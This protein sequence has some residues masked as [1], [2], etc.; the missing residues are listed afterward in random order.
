MD[1]EIVKPAKTPDRYMIAVRYRD[2]WFRIIA[3]ALAAQFIVMYGIEESFFEVLL[4]DLYYIAMAGSIII[5][6]V[7]IT[8][9]RWVTIKLDRRFGWTERTV[10]RV[11]LQVLLGWVA[12]GLFAFLL[13]FIYFSLRGLNILDTLYLR[14]DYP[15]IL[16]MIII[17]N[18]YYLAYYFYERMQFAEKAVVNSPITLEEIDG[19]MQPTF[20]V[21]QGRKSI[22]VPIA[23]IAY[24]FRNGDYNF[25]RTFHGDDYM[26]NQS[27]DEVQ[28]L[29]HATDFFRANR[30]MLVS[31]RSC[32]HFEPLPYNKLELFVEPAYK[33]EIVISQ[34][35]NRSFRDWV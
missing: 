34:K 27:L 9:V 2:F 17:L 8:F 26:I 5:A 24:F 3:S 11:G 4:T 14:F 16:V 30:Q 1:A 28:A 25:L 31:R 21:N 10:E 12:P 35:R 6:F 32:R 20:L 22:P 13:A 18:L 29:L 33:G 15:I 7:L 19:T 23:D